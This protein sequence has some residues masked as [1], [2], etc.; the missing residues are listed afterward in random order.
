MIEAEP[1]LV[2]AYHAVVLM[3]DFPFGSRFR[4]TTCLSYYRGR[5]SLTGERWIPRCGRR[6]ARIVCLSCDGSDPDE[7]QHF[8][9]VVILE[10]G[11]VHQALN[12]NKC[13]VSRSQQ[14]VTFSLLSQWIQDAGED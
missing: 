2:R 10:Q 11:I 8:G 14:Q 13:R 6:R 3:Y 1:Q 12:N 5:Y 9:L 7:N 4:A